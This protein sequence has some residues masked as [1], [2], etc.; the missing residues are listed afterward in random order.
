MGFKAKSLFGFIFLVTQFSSL[1][2]HH[3]KYHVFLAP[4]LTSHHSIFFTLFVGPIPITGAAFSFSFFFF[5]QYPNTLNPVK[6][7]KKKERKP[8][9]AQGKKK[10]KRWSKVAAVGPLYVFNYNIA[11]EL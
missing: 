2:T 5:F 10:V 3:L 8:T 6:E 9:P 1:I 4:S 11:I 7:K